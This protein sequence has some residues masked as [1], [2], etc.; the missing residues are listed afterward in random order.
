M[1][2]FVRFSSFLS[3]S[4]SQSSPFSSNGKYVLPFTLNWFLRNLP[5]P[6]VDVATEFLYESVRVSGQEPIRERTRNVYLE[7]RDFY[8]IV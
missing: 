4:L 8:T 6:I 3:S 7:L 2:R 5:Y 1:V